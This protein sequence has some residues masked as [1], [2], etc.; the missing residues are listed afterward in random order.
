MNYLRDDYD[1][2]DYHVYREEQFMND[3]GLNCIF[4]R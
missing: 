1:D 3:L 4:N 2:D